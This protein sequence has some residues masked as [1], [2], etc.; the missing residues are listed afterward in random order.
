MRSFRS[1][2]NGRAKR[3]TSYTSLPSDVALEVRVLGNPRAKVPGTVMKR[4]STPEARLY[5]L[6]ILRREEGCWGDQK[7]FGVVVAAL[8]GQ[9]E[10][11]PA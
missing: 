9:G 11:L 10:N 2:L 6:R 5:A 8:P 4:K 1:Y 7:V 3:I